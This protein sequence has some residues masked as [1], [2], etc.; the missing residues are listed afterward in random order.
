MFDGAAPQVGDQVLPDLCCGVRV[1]AFPV[2][3]RHLLSYHLQTAAA[4]TACAS[5]ILG[6][7]T[8]A[9]QETG[10]AGKRDNLDGLT[11]NRLVIEIYTTNFMEIFQ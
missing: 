6:H 3:A 11:R 7:A 10:K 4:A 5:P 1:I 8:V 9:G 2:V